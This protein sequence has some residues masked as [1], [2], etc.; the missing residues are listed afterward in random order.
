MV[1]DPFGGAGTTALVAHNL[2]RDSIS[3]ELN[4]KYCDLQ[5]KR[6]RDEADLFIDIE[7]VKI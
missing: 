4:P 5:E 7:R 3:L 6:L 1:L 2:D